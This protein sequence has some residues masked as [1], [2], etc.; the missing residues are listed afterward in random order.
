M[1]PLLP[2]TLRLLFPGLKGSFIFERQHVV[3]PSKPASLNLYI[4]LPFCRNICHFCPYVKFPYNPEMSATYQDALIKELD[5]YKRLW[6][7]VN[8][9]SVYFGGGTPS[10]TPEIVERTLSWISGNFHLSREVGVEIHPLDVSDSLISS[11]KHSG[12]TMASLGIQ[13][14]NDRLLKVLGRGYDGKTAIQACERLF[15]AGFD[16]VDVDLIFAIPSQE[17]R[18]AVND[19]EMACRLDADQI[20]SYPLI[21][22]AYT[23]IKAYLK[24]EGLTLPS[25]RMEKRML[26]AIVKK[27]SAA[28][29]HRTSIWSFNQPET[30][31]YTTVTRDAFIGI[32]AGTS[33]RIGD[34]FWLNTFSATDY[35]KAMADGASPQALATRLNEGDKMAYWLFWQFY[36]TVIDTDTFRST[37]GREMPYRVKALLSLIC[38][39][40]MAHQEGT[41]VR[42]TDT[43]AYLF[44]L[45]E[46]G[47]THAYLEKLWQA[48]FSEPW[49][50]RVLL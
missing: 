32:G 44:H 22:F 43:G 18:E 34:Y 4:H 47:Y 24:K 48:C 2:R 41:T 27:A 39:L 28:G 17:V 37:F 25:L 46:K 42:L 36:N 30:A 5:S 12:V 3:L 40:S 45:I 11:F 19:I 33:S 1:N 16:T 26:N 13:S 9:E 23:P 50:R 49:P 38:L 29:Y 20:S 8:I 15:Q 6:G 21:P 35:T 14:F 31:R 7:D 10:L